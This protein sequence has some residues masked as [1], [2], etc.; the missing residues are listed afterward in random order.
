MQIKKVLHW[1]KELKFDGG[2]ENT[3]NYDLRILGRKGV[4]S[5]NAVGGISQLAE[6]KRDIPKIMDAASFNSGYTYKEFDSKLDEVAA[7]SIG[8]LVAGKVLAKTGLLA[9]IA[10]FGKVIILGAVAAGAWLINLFRRRKNSDEDES[11][12][13]SNQ[14]NENIEEQSSI[15]NEVNNEINEVSDRNSINENDADPDKIDENK[16]SEK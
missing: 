16:V 13:A 5:M 9:I 4:L 10:K 6:I 8:G 2:V 7:V 11:E 14:P 1:A 12:I 15:S 3:L